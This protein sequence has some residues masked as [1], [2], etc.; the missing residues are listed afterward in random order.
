M[1]PQSAPFVGTPNVEYTCLGSPYVTSGFAIVISAGRTTELDQVT[2]RLL[3]GSHVGGP[4]VTFPRPGLTNEF[5][6]TV[7]VAGDTRRFLFRPYFPCG[8][9]RAQAVAADLSF[10]DLGGVPHG[11]TVTTSLR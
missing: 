11:M 1:A 7:I 4:A 10:V 8:A 2:I 5:G 9:G 6:S 3:D